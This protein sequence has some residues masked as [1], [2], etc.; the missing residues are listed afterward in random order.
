M[1]EMTYS[2]TLSVTHCWCG[3]AVAIPENLHRWALE[4]NKH[5]VHCPLGH[6]FVY[7]DSYEAKLAD[8]RRRHQAT[9]E[10]LDAEEQARRTEE[11]SHAQT[12]GQL[13][14]TRERVAAGVCPFCRRSFSQ[15]ARHMKSKHPDEVPSS[16]HEHEH[17]EHEHEHKVSAEDIL[18]AQL[19]ELLKS[20]GA[21]SFGT[22]LASLNLTTSRAYVLLRRHMA[23]G[24][25]RRR[26]HGVYE[27]V[28][29]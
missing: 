6:T 12:R 29:S 13:R 26:H 9:R 21:V 17:H 22:I 7:G 10:L 14:K 24:S 18:D 19:I 20:K 27:W 5:S 23:D 16:G 28:E 25:V 4:S 11:R 3:I 1:A 8:E 2:E 15:L